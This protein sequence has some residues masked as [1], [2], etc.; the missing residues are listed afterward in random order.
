MVAI[1]ICLEILHITGMH[2]CLVSVK[3]LLIENAVSQSQRDKEAV[4]RGILNHYV[5]D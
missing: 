2:K 3:R 4:E 1:C 5:M